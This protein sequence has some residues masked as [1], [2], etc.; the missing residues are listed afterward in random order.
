MTSFKLMVLIFLPLLGTAKGRSLDAENIQVNLKHTNDVTDDDACQDCIQI[1]EL[2]KHLMSDEQFQAKLKTTL[3]EM[4]NSLPDEFS[5]MCREQV[6]NKLPLALTFITSLMIPNDVCSYFGLCDGQLRGQLH[7]L[8]MTHMQKTIGVP[9][10]MLNSSIPCTL[11]TYVADVLECLIPK[12]ETLITTLLGNMCNIL[13]PLLRGQCTGI[14]NK[15]VKMLIKVLMDFASPDSLCSVLR[16]CPTLETSERAV[17]TLSDC[18]S[19]LTLTVLT[20]LRLG[21]NATELQAA[22]FLRTVCQSH[23]DA[24]PKCESFTRRHGI[25]LQGLLGKEMT[26]METC[27]R[28]DLCVR[29]NKSD[30]V[31]AGDPCTLGPSYTCKDQQTAE[32]CGVAVFCQKNVWN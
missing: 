21:S 27:E 31:A 6:E 10:I 18:D 8:L 24:L 19:C 26:A 2:L 13:P 16:L 17:F 20:R 14:V 7:D 5:K 23:P 4:C 29:R 22:S 32:E 30:S 25:Q 15:Y 11:C 1:I 9:T 12:T 3:E 28:A